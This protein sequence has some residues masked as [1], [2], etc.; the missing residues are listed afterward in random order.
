MSM[1]KIVYLYVATNRSCFISVSNFKHLSCLA[2]TL[3]LAYQNLGVRIVISTKRIRLDIA[4][5][6]IKTIKNVSYIEH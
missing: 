1:Y 6:F 5:V 4:S 3:E 2:H